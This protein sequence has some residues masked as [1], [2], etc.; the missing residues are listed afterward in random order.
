M[1]SIAFCDSWTADDSQHHRP[2]EGPDFTS[3]DTSPK[4]YESI[5]WMFKLDG[6]PGGL[7]SET[8]ARLFAIFRQMAQD[9]F[10]HGALNKTVDDMIS[11]FQRNEEGDWRAR[12]FS[13]PALTR[14]AQQHPSAVRFVGNLGKALSKS[15]QDAQGDIAKVPRYKTKIFSPMYNTAIDTLMSGLTITVNDTWAYEASIADCQLTGPSEFRTRPSIVIYDHFGL[16]RADVESKVFVNKL[17]GLARGVRGVRNGK[18]TGRRREA[19][20]CRGAPLRRAVS[21][22]GGSGPVVRAMVGVP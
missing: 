5:G 3:G 17:G 18:S 21:C 1:K 9:L 6:H 15:L 4:E 10:S 22:A 7:E 16:N 2:G 13:D 14:A 12:T 20:G 11:K 19:A 8:D